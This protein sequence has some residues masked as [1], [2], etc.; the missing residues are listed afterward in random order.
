M[1]AAIARIMQLVSP[2]RFRVAIDKWLRNNNHAKYNANVRI[3]TIAES[4]L[5]IARSMGSAIRRI[6]IIIAESMKSFL[7]LAGRILV[8]TGADSAIGSVSVVLGEV[9]SVTVARSSGIGRWN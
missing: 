4:V 6:V 5:V 7:L 3:A 8:P 2:I 9:T 1:E